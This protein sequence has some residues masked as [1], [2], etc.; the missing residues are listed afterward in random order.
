MP[1]LI[2]LPRNRYF[3]RLSPLKTTL[4]GSF[5]CVT[6]VPIF[7]DGLINTTPSE[8]VSFC[9]YKHL[10]LKTIKYG[11]YPSFVMQILMVSSSVV[12]V[13]GSEP[14]MNLFL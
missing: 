3:P 12:N 10:G 6:F 14:G 4:P 1:I 8:K 11:E 7:I 9:K 2:F 5:D 13:A